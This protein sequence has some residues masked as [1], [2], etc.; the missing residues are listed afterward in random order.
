MSL[1]IH[2]KTEKISSTPIACHVAKAS[3]SCPPRSHGLR[4]ALQVMFKILRAL[5]NEALY[6]FHSI[7]I[8]APTGWLQWMAYPGTV[9]DPPPSQ[10]NRSRQ[11]NEC[12][13]LSLFAMSII[14]CKCLQR[15]R[16]AAVGSTGNFMNSM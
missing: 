1:K 10:G 9:G 12:M 5:H 3:L 2:Y 8:I 13:C 7:I 16:S 11:R 15:L 14:F 4:C 6:A